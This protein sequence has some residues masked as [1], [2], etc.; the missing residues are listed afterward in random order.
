MDPSRC[1]SSSVHWRSGKMVRLILW[2]ILGSSIPNCCRA[3]GRARWK[4]RVRSRNDSFM[5]PLRPEEIVAVQ[6]LQRLCHRL[7]ADIVLIGAMAYRI[8]IHDL[9]RHTLD[10]DFAIAVDLDDY[11]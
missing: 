1:S 10:I 2:R 7:G 4:P 6:E 9:H 3:T 11:E 5:Q 8:W